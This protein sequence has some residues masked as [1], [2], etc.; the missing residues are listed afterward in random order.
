MAEIWKVI[1]SCVPDVAEKAPA[2]KRNENITVK[3]IMLNFKLKI[4]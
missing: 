2:E 3:K 4:N 1:V